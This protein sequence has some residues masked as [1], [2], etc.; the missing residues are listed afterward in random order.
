MSRI[1]IDEQRCKG[2]LLCVEACPKSI[3]VASTRFNA[4]GYKVAELPQTDMD[5]CTGCA[6]CAQMCPDVAITVWRTA[7]SKAKENE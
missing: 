3:V 7:K 5:K 4:K 1:V 6:S 2:C